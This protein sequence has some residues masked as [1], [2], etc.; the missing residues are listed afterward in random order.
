VPNYRF[1]GHETFPCRYAW[2]PKAFGALQ[3]NQRI[4]SDEE[5]A[6][7]EMGVGKNMVRAIR[8]WVQVTGVAEPAA[9][10]SYELTPF[11]KLLLGSRGLDRFLEDRRTLWLLHWK[12]LSHVEEPLFAWDYLINRWTQP[13]ISREEVVKT[14]ELEAKRI[15]RKLSRVTLEQHFDVF[16]HTYTPTR[17]RKGEIQEDN[18]DCPLVE[19]E[20]IKQIGERNLG[21][22]SER[23]EPVYAFRRE[24]KSDI[25]SELFIYCLYDYW[26]KRRP[27]EA[28][29]T[30]RDVS[31]S[32]GSIGQ[33]FKLPEMDVR[34]RLER[35]EADS[36]GLFI[37]QESA[38][39]QRVI[40][41]D[42]QGVSER[43]LLRAIYQLEN[44]NDF[45]EVD[46]EL[47]PLQIQNLRREGNSQGQLFANHERVAHD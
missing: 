8:F 32:H 41:S 13:E 35:L 29:L 7:V 31:V 34:E 12:L 2:L 33:V 22:G 40:C 45:T 20:L 36:S 23:R 44:S 11:G 43:E 6:I 15:D 28:T 21:G 16:L 37:Y 42:R 5:R 14:F 38:A 3:R 30:F 27:N 1:S 24:P 4:F 47:N 9:N 39:L 10:G 17:S 26:Q 46:A 18:L 19:L 25:T